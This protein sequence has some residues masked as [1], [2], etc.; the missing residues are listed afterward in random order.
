MEKSPIGATTAAQFDEIVA[1]N[2]R[3]PFLLAQAASR[4]MRAGSVVVNIADHMAEE[5]WPDY[6]VHGVA[7]SGVVALTRHL[8]A[9]LAPDIRVN[10]VAPGFV[11]APPGFPEAAA[12]RFASETPLK[13]LGSPSDVAHAVRYLI[14][15]EFVTGETVHV[16]GGRRLRP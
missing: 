5:P 3:A 16:D 14:D 15:A 1:L 7:K 8:A 4:V 10:A 12:Q 6:A 2:L 13:R 9:A 11:L